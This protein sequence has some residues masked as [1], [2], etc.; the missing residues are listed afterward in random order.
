MS[1]ACGHEELICINEAL[2]E[3]VDHLRTN[4]VTTRG[5]GRSDRDPQIR[6]LSTVFLHQSLNRVKHDPGKRPSPAG[7]NSGKRTCLRIA[8]KHW[9]TVSSLNS[10]QHMGHVTD[11]RIAVDRIAQRALRRFRFGY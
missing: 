6:R 8:N 9:H 10:R 7:M 11:D 1:L 3:T 4:F 5:S 2:P